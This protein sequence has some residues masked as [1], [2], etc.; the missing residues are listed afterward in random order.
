MVRAGIHQVTPPPE[1]LDLEDGIVPERY[2]NVFFL[3]A[4]RNAMMGPLPEFVSVENPAKYDN[5]TALEF[6]KHRTKWLHSIRYT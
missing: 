6:Q 2:S 1:M 4:D 5:M 3:K